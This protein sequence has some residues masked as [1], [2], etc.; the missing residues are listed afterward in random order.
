MQIPPLPLDQGP[1]IA[2][3][4]SMAKLPAL[5]EFS[6]SFPRL[7]TRVFFKC[8]KGKIFGGEVLSTL[9]V[10]VLQRWI[11]VSGT[12]ADL[13][14]EPSSRQKALQKRI[15][16]WG[17]QTAKPPLRI[18]RVVIHDRRRGHASFSQ[19]QARPSQAGMQAQHTS[20]THTSIVTFRPRA[21]PPSVH[22]GA[23][24]TSRCMHLLNFSRRQVRERFMPAAG[25][26]FVKPEAP[27][28]VGGMDGADSSAGGRLTQRRLG[29]GERF[30]WRC[31]SLNLSAPSQTTP[32][33]AT[34]SSC[35]CS[36]ERCPFHATHRP[37]REIGCRT[38]PNSIA[39]HP[40]SYSYS[41]R[42]VRCEE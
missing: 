6:S 17:R 33:L 38:S 26:F 12:L 10:R 41:L 42:D 3:S 30:R 29:S 11:A 28:S 18:A 1:S 7:R 39:T 13:A 15:F 31:R 27:G 23:V 22:D 16:M 35:F 34:P 37:M 2:H 14:A 4:D 40:T 8:K 21:V 5:A 24:S 19:A 9:P 20:H 32:R 36:E 25:F